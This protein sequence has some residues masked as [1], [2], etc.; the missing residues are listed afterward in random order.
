MPFAAVF[1]YSSIVPVSRLPLIAFG[2]FVNG[3]FP[4]I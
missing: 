4:K 1:P 2:M 3:N